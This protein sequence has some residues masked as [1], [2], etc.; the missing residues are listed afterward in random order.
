[1]ESPAIERRIAPVRQRDLS[2]G[3]RRKA[4]HQFSHVLLS[5]AAASEGS[6]RLTAN[7]PCGPTVYCP[8]LTALWIRL[9]LAESLAFQIPLR[10]ARDESATAPAAAH[11]HR[12]P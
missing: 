9:A 3:K 5:P 12:P 4:H 6:N 7:R 8:D 2:S 1:M 10:A 11:A